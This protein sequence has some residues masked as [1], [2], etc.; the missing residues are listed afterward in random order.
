MADETK[1]PETVEDF[2]AQLESGTG[3]QKAE[4]AAAPQTAEAEA[5]QQQ[6]SE[7]AQQQQQQQQPEPEVD[8]QTLRQQFARLQQENKQVKAAL[9]SL[10]QQQGQRQ[11]EP[12]KEEQPKPQLPP[13]EFVQEVLQKLPQ[14]EKE[15]LE[16]LQYDNPLEASA[17]VALLVNAAWTQKLMEEARQREAQMRAR[18]QE[19]ER[20][21]AYAAQELT[22]LYGVDEA[23]LNEIAELITREK[24]ALL[25]LPP[26]VAMRDAYETWKRRKGKDEIQNA[27]AQAFRNPQVVAEALKDPQV[28]SVVAQALRP[29]VVKAAAETNAAVPVLLTNQPGGV[30]AAVA[31]EKPKSVREA[32]LRWLAAGGA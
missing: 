2:F 27:V 11:Q 23:A 32:G 15:R 7:Q 21:F 17:Q 5:G 1:K 12:P 18:Q 29:E 6:Q 14:E 16:Q 9:Q 26:R 4:E 10:L 20:E 24:P 13:R 30:S 3:E 25:Q 31:P 8:L 28:L 19:L 22:E